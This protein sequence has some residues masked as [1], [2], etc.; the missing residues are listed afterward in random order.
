MA[1]HRFGHNGPALRVAEDAGVFL[2]A[3]VE[4]NRADFGAVDVLIR[5]SAKHKA[6]IGGE[7][8]H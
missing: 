3:L 2:G 4:Q 1:K 5:R 8:F 6:V 7:L